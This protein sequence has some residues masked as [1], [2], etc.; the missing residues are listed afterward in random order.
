MVGDERNDAGTS[1]A[2]GADHGRI[3]ENKHRADELGG[4]IGETLQ[5]TDQ[6][7]REILKPGVQKLN[8]QLESTREQLNKYPERFFPERVKQVEPNRGQNQQHPKPK[9]R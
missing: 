9:T 2:E 8:Q 1:R 6:S 4:K 5:R 7:I 3:I